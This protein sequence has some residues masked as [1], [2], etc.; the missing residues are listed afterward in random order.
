MITV[1]NVSCRLRTLYDLT[2]QAAGESSEGGQNQRYGA[3]GF[4]VPC[5]GSHRDG[6]DGT[7]SAEPSEPLNS[8][9]S[10]AR[11]PAFI[12]VPYLVRAA[13]AETQKIYYRRLPFW[14]L[15]DN[16]DDDARPSLAAVVVTTIQLQVN[17]LGLGFVV[18]PC[19]AHTTRTT[20]LSNRWIA[21]AAGT[22]SS[23]PPLPVDGYTLSSGD[24]IPSVGLGT[25]RM[26]GEEAGRAVKVHSEESFDGENP[27][28]QF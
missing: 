2:E 1:P 11:Y 27:N 10:A 22:D 9:P 26:S 24:V 25:W 8:L 17:M 12:S 7:A 28:S 5:T 6:W 4:P 20:T 18:R 3:C 13:K 16:I 15:N 14:T 23:R 21:S 19:L